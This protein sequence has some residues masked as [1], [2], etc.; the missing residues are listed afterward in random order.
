MLTNLLNKFTEW[1]QKNLPEVSHVADLLAQPL[2]DESSEL[3]EQLSEL[4]AWNARCGYW[5]SEANSYLSKFEY[6]Y[7][8][9]KGDR[10]EEERKIKNKFDT[11]DYRRVRD[12]LEVLC[13]SIKQ[14]LIMGESILSF[15][16]QF[17]I[18]G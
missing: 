3:I 18:K 12:Q 10:T 15:Q 16:K 11:S 1:H 4:E 13:D 17:S 6:A 14:R 8:G 5:L 9:E 2:S 7:L